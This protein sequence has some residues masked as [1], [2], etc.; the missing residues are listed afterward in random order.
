M[1]QTLPMLNRGET[2]L[3]HSRRLVAE[4][5][6]TVTRSREIRAEL[7]AMVQAKRSANRDVRPQTKS[8]AEQLMDVHGRW[9]RHVALACAARRAC[10]NDQR[11]E[12]F[13]L[14][15]LAEIIDI[16]VAPA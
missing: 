2:V 13:W 9:A 10:A 8:C 11:A 3:A 16:Q 5:G 14:G 1:S 7:R 12:S 4:A 15:V 6:V